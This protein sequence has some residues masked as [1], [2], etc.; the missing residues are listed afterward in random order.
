MFE[1]LNDAIVVY[2]RIFDFSG[3]RIPFS[4]F[5][6]ALIKYYKVHF[7]QLGPFGPQQG[8]Y[9]RGYHALILLCIDENRSCMK[10]WKSGFFLIDWRA[11]PIYM[12]WRHPDSA[13]NDP[14]PP[15]GSFNMENVLRLSAYVVKLRDTLEGVLVLSG[16]SRVWKSRT[17]DPVLQGTDGNVMGNHDFLCLPEWTGAEIQEEPHHDISNPSAKVVAKTE[18]SQKRKAFTFDAASSPVAKHTSDDDD[19]ACFEIM[20]R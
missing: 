14:K 10:H 4:S 8:C 6:L 11:I 2:H 13:I 15:A 12:S 20:M 3:V 1:L 16:L 5:L 7:S 9:F 18:S 17:C 19:D